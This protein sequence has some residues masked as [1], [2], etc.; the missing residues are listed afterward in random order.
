MKDSHDLFV[1]VVGYGSITTGFGAVFNA[2]LDPFPQWGLALSFVVSLAV[3]P[4]SIWYHADVS[5]TQ[6]EY[7]GT[8]PLSAQLGFIS[9][10]FLYAFVAPRVLPIGVALVVATGGVLAFVY[11][12]GSV[13]GVMV[14]RR[15]ADASALSPPEQQQD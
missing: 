7:Q 8:L 9:T 15:M 12:A 10:M 5:A 2:F 1:R 6:I 13:V 3:L 11:V 14:F 4:L